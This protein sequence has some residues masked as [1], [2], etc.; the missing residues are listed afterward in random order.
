M[1]NNNMNSIEEYKIKLEQEF[2][3]SFEER[4]AFTKEFTI[5]KKKMKDE[6]S[7]FRIGKIK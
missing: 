5:K 3:V 2:S 6:E 7:N 1:S 4:G